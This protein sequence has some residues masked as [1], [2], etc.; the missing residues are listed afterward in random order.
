MLPTKYLHKLAAT[1]AKKTLCTVWPR[2]GCS[3]GNYVNE[4]IFA[5]GFSCL[6]NAV[7]VPFPTVTTK[8]LTHR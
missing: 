7:H 5:N 2:G 4:G 3:L 1:S 6:E 8:V